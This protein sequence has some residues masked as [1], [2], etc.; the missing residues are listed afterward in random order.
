MNREDLELYEEDALFF[1]NP[2]YDDAIIGQ[3]HNGR[4]VY[5]F[6]LIAHSLVNQGICEDYLEAVDYISYDIEKAISY[7]EGLGML[8][9]IIVEM[10]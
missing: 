6:D 10:F 8:A 2:S 3:T 5:D 7:W 9:P 4:I 1:D